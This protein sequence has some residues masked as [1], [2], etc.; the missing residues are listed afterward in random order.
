MEIYTVE[1]WDNVFNR[2]TRESMVIVGRGSLRGS[3]GTSRI[4]F[5]ARDVN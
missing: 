3:R 4:D 1:T 2:E 5:V